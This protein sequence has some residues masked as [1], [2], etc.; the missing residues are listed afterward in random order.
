MKEKKYSTECAE[1][2]V[3]SL[4]LPLE[5]I[6][7]C[8]GDPAV[9]VENEVL[10]A[11]QALRLGQG[12]RGDVTILPTLIINNAQYREYSINILTL[13]K[14]ILNTNECLE[15][16]GGC[17]QDKKSNVT[18]CKDTFRGRVCKCP[19][20]NGVRMFIKEMAILHVSLS[21][22]DL[23][24]INSPYG[25]AICSINQGG[26]WSEIRKGETFLACLNSEASGGRRPPGFK[27][28]GLKCEDIDECKEKSAC[29]CDGCKC[30]NKWERSGSRIGWFFTFVILPAVAG[31]C[32]AGYVFYKY[33]LRSYMDSEIM[34]IMSQY[35]PLDSQNTNDPMTGEPQ[36]QQLRLTS[37]A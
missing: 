28:D 8:M 34:T 2:V 31:I 25:P 23:N 4:G 30:K 21:L 11:E 33:R 9:D 22:L 1:S 14:Q 20:V 16:N 6:K 5:K 27:G 36:Q 18:A 7:K 12:D 32:V 37:A 3:K 15:A 10:K 24:V 13:L 17:W 29:Q 35:M 26:C 19:V